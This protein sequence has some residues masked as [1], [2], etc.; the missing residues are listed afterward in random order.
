[1]RIVC[2]SSCE[3]RRR[4][5]FFFFIE[6]MSFCN[7]PGCCLSRC[8]RLSACVSS[9]LHF[10]CV[11]GPVSNRRS[12]I[13]AKAFRIPL[14]RY[15]RHT[16]TDRKCI[17]REARVPSGFV[18]HTKNSSEHRWPG[19]IRCGR[20]TKEFQVGISFTQEML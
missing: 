11:C 12:R 1:M 8:I 15:T 16:H 17:R 19:Q 5:N 14:A 7:S 18:A 9:L 10:V 2:V 4:S 3:M 6:S 13:F 20:R